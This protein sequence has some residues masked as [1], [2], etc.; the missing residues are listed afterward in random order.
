M[1]LQRILIT[2]KCSTKFLLTHPLC[3]HQIKQA[4][5]HL[6]TVTVCKP[7]RQRRIYVTTNYLTPK[8]VAVIHTWSAYL[9]GIVN[10][11]KMENHFVCRIHGNISRCNGCRGIID[12]QVPPNDLVIMHEE[13]HYYPHPTTRQM[14]LSMTPKPKY[15]HFQLPCLKSK[16]PAFSF[17]DLVPSSSGPQLE[18]SH[19]QLIQH[20]SYFG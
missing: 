8:H 14:V 11:G 19:L 10:P 17:K 1:F 20:C 13:C 12:K 7:A 3:I 6:V 16:H 4:I 2:T 5:F 18:E 15:Y 9:L